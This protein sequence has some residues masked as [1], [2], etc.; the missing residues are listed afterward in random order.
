MNTDTESAMN[1]LT[2]A[3]CRAKHAMAEVE[4]CA[5]RYKESINNI[6]CS[7]ADRRNASSVEESVSVKICGEDHMAN[8]KY[9]DGE[10]PS[11]KTRE[12]K[13]E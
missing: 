4:R 8:L 2:K 5:E 7:A 1:E 11:E 9:L 6:T 3:I 10:S 12:S 13:D